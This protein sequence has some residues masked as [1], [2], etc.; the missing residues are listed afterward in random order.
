MTL[1]GP[2]DLSYRPAGGAVNRYRMQ[3]EYR[4]LDGRGLVAE[5]QICCGEFTRHPTD[6]PEGSERIT[7][8]GLVYRSAGCETQ[9]KWAEGFTYV[10]S[11]DRGFA[12]LTSAAAALPRTIEGWNVFVLMID[13]HA[14]FDLP[15][16]KE[17]SIESLRRPGEVV[18]STS[19]EAFVIDFSPLLVAEFPAGTYRQSRFVGIG[20][21]QGKP[22]AVLESDIPRRQPFEIRTPEATLKSSSSLRR[23]MRIRLE[24]GVLE[25][26]VTS[27]WVCVDGRWINPTYTI[28]RVA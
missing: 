27:E 15:R 14:E 2:Y 11:W 13:A 10:Y 3:A 22:W 7:W 9:L 28:A 26:G 6:R 19:P 1:D 17:Q 12:A 25:D 16:S 21:E 8:T 4:Y 5:R 20:D 18:E 23:E 24:D